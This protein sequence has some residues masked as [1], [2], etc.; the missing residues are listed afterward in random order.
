LRRTS[1]SEKTKVKASAKSKAKV[2]VE[3]KE[4]FKDLE[5]DILENKVAD[6]V[7]VKRC[8]SMVFRRPSSN[9]KEPRKPAPPVTKMR[10]S[11]QKLNENLR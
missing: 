2:K 11:D 4:N 10:L 1:R 9:T 8:Q 7:K 3:V 5:M 6:S